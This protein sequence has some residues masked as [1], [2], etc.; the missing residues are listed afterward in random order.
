MTDLFGNDDTVKKIQLNKYELAILIDYGVRRN[1]TG[2][3]QSLVKALY[4]RVNKVT[5][6]LE[7]DAVLLERI[8]RY[9]TKY[10]QGG[11]QDSFLKPV[12]GRTLNL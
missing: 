1:T 2:G 9:A 7:L 8:K 6:E 4:N 12:F 10:K 3:F 11:F 5:G